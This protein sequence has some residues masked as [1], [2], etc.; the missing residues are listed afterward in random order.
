M[1]LARRA[2]RRGPV[3][4]GVD[5]GRTA[6]KRAEP[7]R[8]GRVRVRSLAARAAAVLLAVVA[9]LLALPLQAQAQTVWS[10]TL[11]VK[12]LSGSL[13]CDNAVTGAECSTTSVLTDDD[14]TH[15]STDYS[16]TQIR[17]YSSSA[18][19]LWFDVIPAAET[20][21]LRLKEDGTRAGSPSFFSG[22]SYIQWNSFRSSLWAASDT[23][24]LQL[25][26]PTPGAPTGLTATASGTTTINLSWTAP[27]DDGGRVITGY[28]IEISSDSASTWTTHVANTSSTTTTNAHTGLAAGATRHYRVSAINIFGAGTASNV[29]SATTDTAV[30]TP[31]TGAPTITGTPQV[32]QTLTAVTTAIMDANGLNNVSYTYQWIRVDGSDSDIS[33]ATASTYTLV[34]ADQGKTIKV[35]VSFTDD[36]S[37][38]ETLTSVATAAVS[39]A[40]NTPATGAPTITGTPQVDQTLTA[41]TTA[42]MDANGLNN[43]SYTYQWIRVDGSDSDISGATAS[44]YT[45]VT[46]DQGKT[47]KVKVSFTDDAS[48]AETL[49]SVATAA[50]SAAPNTPA[51]GAPTITGT[52]Q[53]DQT[54]TAVTTAIMDANGLNN[55]S[56][57]YQWI[58]VDGSDSDISGAT[59]STYTLVTADQ[60]KTIKVKVSFTD[61]AS[62]AETLTSV[63]TAAVSAAPNTPAT[64]A[65][66][67]TGTPQV[68]QTLTAV[69]TAIMDAN[70]LNNVSYTYQWIRV[71]GSDSDISGA[72]AST[73][74][75]VTAD[76]GKTIKVKVSFTD[77][78]SNAETLTSVATAAVSAAPN[79]PATGAP[80]ITGTPQVDQ[81]LTAVTTAIMD[82]NGLNNVSYT[83][84]WIRVDGSD[85]D[86]SGATASTYT[87]VT[88]DQGKTIKVKVSFTDDASNA[89]TLTSV[90]T[91]A[92]SAAPNT[93]ATGA[94]TIT[95]TP[96]VDQTLTAVTTA[97][98][99]ANGL[100]NVS[101][102]YQWIRVDGS[103]S[104]ISGAT[105][106]T[107]TLV[108]AD[109]GKTIKV[110]VSF[111]DDASNAETLTSVATAAVSAAPNTPATGAPTITGTPQVDQTLTAVTTAI[112]DANGLNNVSY[113]Y[114]WIRVD[115][116][117]SD[118]SG[119]TAST[120]T[121]V[122][123]DQGK[124]IKVKV[125][126]TDDASNAETLTSVATAA[127]SAA[128]NTPATARRRSP[129]RRRST[130]R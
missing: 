128:P 25:Q 85:S 130:R 5:A 14:F 109:Q 89:E 26:E 80:T 60:G 3:D 77:D 16:I 125:S 27:A 75:L 21:Q 112:M 78:A 17:Q 48:N 34:T 23:V 82:A 92:V 62:N 12:D 9:A 31:A 55:V 39:A 72:T 124:T 35:K 33:G 36:A 114:Q 111:T 56:Y 108:T 44:T 46:A 76:Q 113:T 13:G 118:I 29:D 50:V 104:D 95:G 11:T 18:I 102:T 59:A 120:Y 10:G 8:P 129:A 24:Q 40:P 100:N 110:K 43:V 121:L 45:L 88:A 22:N 123:A 79:T 90:A 105:A 1:A 97:I 107:Y 71:D 83:Y 91:A 96:Q 99:D 106:S 30:N 52:P 7:G 74:T 65:P 119:A 49:T 20:A 32:D 67:I 73:Y 38:A 68:D 87:L 41:V 116:S 19:Q 101:Y 61:D 47:I 4:T 37:N 51:T 28:K 54:L 63:A 86:I 115:G 15:A 81:T 57:T 69:T 127:V 103:D 98:M 94:P 93:P 42:I 64:G 117:D 53:V 126:F 84:Q 66:T 70:G 122:T 58:R 2:P 6:L